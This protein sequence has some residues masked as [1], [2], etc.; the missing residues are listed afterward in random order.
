MIARLA[1]A[2]VTGGVLAVIGVIL[3]FLTRIYASKPVTAIMLSVAPKAAW[4]RL[5]PL[6]KVLI[7]FGLAGAG[8]VLTGIATGMT[9]AGII[10]AALSAGLAAV[11]LHATTKA[12]VETA[13][14][15]SMS[16]ELGYEPGALRKAASIA[17][18]FDAE[19]IAAKVAKRNGG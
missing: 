18:P 14:M 7:P 10:A 11:G 4:P 1:A 15:A 5:S 19:K 3:M 12:I 8:A 17:V 13:D 6:A 16:K 2:Q 9:V